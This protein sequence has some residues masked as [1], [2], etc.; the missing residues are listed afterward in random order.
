MHKLSNANKSE[1]NDL[2]PLL[3]MD[4]LFSLPN[5]H[6]YHLDSEGKYINCNEESC[7]FLKVSKDELLNKT[8]FDFPWRESAAEWRSND[9]RVMSSERACEFTEMMLHQNTEYSLTAV[10]LPVY[11]RSTVG[12]VLS[13]I[14]IASSSPLASSSN[15]QIISQRELQ[16][17]YYL[18]RGFALKQIA[19][20]LKISPR[21]VEHH[22]NKSKIKLNCY[23]R[24]DLIEK[25][26]QLSS[27]KNRLFIDSIHQISEFK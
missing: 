15:N 6:V 7:Q 25:A 5:W 27:I 16:C 21:T 19:H 10:K 26:S 4:S 20:V 3:G 23:H 12:G 8:N 11:V 9:I 13:L 22:I 17:L 24:S 18:I 2:M 14:K 1:I